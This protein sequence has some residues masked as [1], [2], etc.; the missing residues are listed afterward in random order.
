MK[1]V[2]FEVNFVFEYWPVLAAQDKKKNENALTR[3]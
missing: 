2:D 1:N 3:I